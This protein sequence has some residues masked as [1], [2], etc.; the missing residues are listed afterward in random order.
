MGFLS[1]AKCKYPILVFSNTV[2]H[3]AAN[4]IECYE[5]IDC[6]GNFK[7]AGSAKECCTSTDTSCSYKMAAGEECLKCIGKFYPLMLPTISSVG[8]TLFDVVN[9]FGLLTTSCGYT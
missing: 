3:A 8:V 4:A 7:V 1:S 5:S 9:Y 2:P 6:S